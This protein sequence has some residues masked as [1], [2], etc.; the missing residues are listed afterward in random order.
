MMP[1]GTAHAMTEMCLG[2][3][4]AEL[5]VALVL[6]HLRTRMLQV[7]SRAEAVSAGGNT[8]C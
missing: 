4:C 5:H 1:H 2:P 3:R 8:K 6:S 7:F